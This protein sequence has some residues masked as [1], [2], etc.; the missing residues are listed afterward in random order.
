M[1]QNP[2]MLLGLTAAIV[3]AL[4]HRLFAQP[5][6]RLALS[7]IRLIARREEQP[8]TPR[9]WQ[10]IALLA[11]RLAIWTLLAL[12]L[13]RPHCKVEQDIELF[14]EAHAA[15][16]VLD[17]GA[18]SHHRVSG[19]SLWQ[20]SIRRAIALIDALP[21]GS[22]IQIAALEAR[23]PIRQPGYARQQAKA[24]LQAWSDNATPFPREGLLSLSSEISNVE[25]HISL[26]PADLPKVGYFIGELD[27]KQ[28]NCPPSGSSMK[29]WYC[30]SS[31]DTQ[32]KISPAP[33]LGLSALRVQPAPELGKRTFEL[34]VSVQNYASQASAPRALELRW[35]VDDHLAQR[36]Q[37]Q[38]SGTQSKASWIYGAS[39]DQAHRIRAEIAAQ[40]N[41]SPDDRRETWLAARRPLQIL[42]VD[43]DP[44]EE[45]SHDEVYLLAMALRHAFNDRGIVLRS[46][47]PAQFQH[48][49]SSEGS[50]PKR[51]D[52]V[53]MAN[54]AALDKKHAQK[55]EHWVKSG[56]GL[57][58]TA[59]NRVDAK[60]Y[61]QHLASLLP[62]SLR[63]GSVALE[64][65]VD[66]SPPELSHPIFASF[67]DTQSLGGART[68][69]IFLLEPDPSRP[70]RVALRFSNGAPA[71]VTRQLG[72]GRIAWWST[73][74]DRDWS[75]LA[76]HPAFVGLCEAIATWL[77]HEQGPARSK[78]KR[79]PWVAQPILLSQSQRVRVQGPATD[80][81]EWVDA[82]QQFRPRRRGLY[83]T[84]R[85]QG[86]GG[87]RFSVQ[88]NP[89][90]SPPPRPPT[91][92][93]AQKSGVRPPKS[94]SHRYQPI[95]SELWILIALGLVA[96]TLFRILRMRE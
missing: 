92:S 87:E 36:Q 48:A 12:T 58:I 3:I 56:V 65:P 33:Q 20:H 30:V 42:L 75:E 38:L 59:G 26:A 39:D 50:A 14:D 81:S 60:L 15:L 41:F 62:L 91:P 13:A 16:I 95:W 86:P 6:K 77:A 69:R 73:S 63:S 40:D 71:L 54:S 28:S 32:I 10:D 93:S 85:P 96:E 89:A 31:L 57:W 21:E 78:A 9:R 5:A 52:L 34:Q 49:L 66:L 35:Y 4:A 47:D 80:S 8:V 61:N 37:L 1:V 70:A 94:R 84:S 76:L 88:L 24:L 7:S 67:S 74:I 27:A 43:G 46:M 2:W 25:A 23:T 55:L 83:L 44:S 68:R 82:G 17:A 64:G 90:A 11:L 53:V 79:D 22:W 19:K 45:R 29:H 72:Q 18:R 51:C